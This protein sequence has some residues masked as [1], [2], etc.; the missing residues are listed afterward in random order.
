MRGT[1]DGYLI[2]LDMGS[3]ALLWSRE[4]ASAA[5]S[6]YVSAPPL[7][8]KDMVFIGP[9]GAD[10][11]PKN[12]IGAFRL[13]NGEP[14]WRFNLIPD[15]GEPGSETRPDQEAMKHGGGSI[16]TPLSLDA[17]AGVLF[18]PVGNPA[19]DFYG[20]VRDGLN[21]YTDSVVALDANTGKLLWYQQTVPHD[22]HDPI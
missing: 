3:G 22:E 7:I 6:Q 14:V 5:S 12:W 19:T 15:P 20:G 9:P 16:W 17:K 11:G 4:I 1:A 10:Y 21:L 8:H 2:A 13:D 18:L